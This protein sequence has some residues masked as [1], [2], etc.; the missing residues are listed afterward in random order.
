MSCVLS[1]ASADEPA[2]APGIV[3][4]WILRLLQASFRAFSRGNP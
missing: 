4:Y 1:S 2:N 3:L